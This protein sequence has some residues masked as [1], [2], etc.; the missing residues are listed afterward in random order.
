METLS[1]YLTFNDVLIMPGYTDFERSDINLETKLSRRITLAAPFVSSPMNTVTE[2]RLTIALAKAGGIGVIHRNLTID[3]QV[4]EVAAVK[5]A[6]CLV[7]AAVGSSKGYEDRVK[8]LVEAGVDAILI[9]SAHGYQ[10][11][12]IDAVRYVKAHFDVDVIAGSGATAE[13]ATTLIEAGADSLRIGMGP[14]AIRSN[15]NDKI[16]NL[17]RHGVARVDETRARSELRGR[18]PWQNI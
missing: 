15:E 17:S 4:S 11:K 9:D 16:Q 6:R 5:K 18:V 3:D 12:V 14:G 1:Q 10:K 2:H 13:A 7:A 8:A